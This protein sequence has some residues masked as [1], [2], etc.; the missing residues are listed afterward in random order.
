MVFDKCLGQGF[1]YMFYG[2]LL[3][4]FYGWLEFEVFAW[5]VGILG[6]GMTFFG[7]F[8]TAFIG[9][10]LWRHQSRSV[11]MH[12]HAYNTHPHIDSQTL[13]HQTLV[14]GIALL[15]GSFLMFLPGYV[16]DGLGLCCFIPILRI[17]IGRFLLNRLRD[18][19]FVGR[20]GRFTHSFGGL[21]SSS[22]FY[23]QNVSDVHVHSMHAG[24][25]RNHDEIHGEAPSQ[26]HVEIV[27]GEIIDEDISSKGRSDSS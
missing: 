24:P 20:M 13:A 4:G 19:L 22:S 15:F 18:F 14:R 8:V 23:A 21:S 12:W 1:G 2:F 11:L 16:T 9:V 3:F 25:S 6:G 17:F 7:I 10:V 26:N 27:E 5:I